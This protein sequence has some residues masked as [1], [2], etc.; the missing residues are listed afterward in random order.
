MKVLWLIP[1]FWPARGGIE[2]FGWHLAQGLRQQGHD[3]LIVTDEGRPAAPSAEI[4]RNEFREGLQIVRLPV[5]QALNERSPLQLL[6]IQRQMAALATEFQPAVL[7]LHL[8]GATPMAT[9][10]LRL[11]QTHTVPL[12][13]TVHDDVWPLRAGPDT[14]L[15]LSLQAAAW[16][17]TDSQ[18]FLADVLALAPDLAGSTGIAARASTILLG[19][20][21]L[22]APPLPLDLG[23]TQ[24]L[25]LART[26]P[27]KGMDLAVAALSRV[28]QT[29]PAARLV[30][31]GAATSESTTDSLRT[32]AAALGVEQ[33]VHFAGPVTDAQRTRLMEDSLA[34]LMPSRHR[35]GFGLVALEA[36]QHG[37]AVI[38]ARSGALPEIVSLLGNGLL[39]AQ[40]DV[41]GL[42]AAMIYLLDHPDEAQ[43]L[44]ESGRQQAAL[45]F[46]QDKCTASYLALYQHLQTQSPEVQ[47]G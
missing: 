3:L 37:R 23:A 31:A 10:A 6:A 32:Q 14:A 7:H 15:G 21:A 29:H 25:G 17:T 30:L 20:P 36:A 26:T 4:V 5:R 43:R 40:E 19:A 13:V 1:S 34:V 41:E 33:Y 16:V 8:I 18:T 28:L 47:H 12:L 44:G 38:A 27:E 39:T 45:H 46:R 24:F 42:A 11:H 2:T 22:K 35:E 9:F